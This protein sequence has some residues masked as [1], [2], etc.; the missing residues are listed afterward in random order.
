MSTEVIGVSK[1]TSTAGKRATVSAVVAL[2]VSTDGDAQ[3]RAEGAA[4]D[5]APVDA[6]LMFSVDVMGERFVA[7]IDFL[8]TTGANKTVVFSGADV[9]L[10]P[11]VV[12]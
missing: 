1:T 5:G 11:K 10:G 3:G 8:G 9:V 6:H 7:R 2:K 4:R 12:S